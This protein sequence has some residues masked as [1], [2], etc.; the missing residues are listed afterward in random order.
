MFSFLCVKNGVNDSGIVFSA[1]VYEILKAIIVMI[2]CFRLTVVFSELSYAAKNE[3]KGFLLSV[4]Y[5]FIQFLFSYTVLVSLNNRFLSLFLYNCSIPLNMISA[6]ECGVYDDAI[7]GIG[8]IFGSMILG[9]TI[10]FLLVGIIM[11]NYLKINSNGILK[12]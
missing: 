7:I 1:I 12:K 4:L 9:I 5:V 8:A 6:L 11:A 2:N 10:D 3:A